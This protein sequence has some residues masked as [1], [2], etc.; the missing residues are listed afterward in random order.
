VPWLLLSATSTAGTGVLTSVTYVQRV[1]TVGGKAPA[2]GCDS[3]HAGDNTSVNYTAD[4]F[5]WAP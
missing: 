3:T 4:Y 5:F 2:T 1:N